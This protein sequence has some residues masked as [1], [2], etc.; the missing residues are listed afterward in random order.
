MKSPALR[1]FRLKLQADEPV[2]GLWVT[3]EAPAITDIATGLGLDWVVIDAELGHLDWAEVFEHI[4]ATARSETV[5]LVRL[6][7]ANRELIRRALDLGADGVVIPGIETAEQLRS[8]VKWAQC[9]IANTHSCSKER[10]TTQGRRAPSSPELNPYALVVP[11]LPPVRGGA[12]VR[13]M[14]EVD[15]VEVFFFG[16]SGDSASWGSGELGGPAL[17]AEHNRMVREIRKRRKQA[18]IVVP[19]AEALVACRRRQIGVLGLGFDGDII[20]RNIH[21]LLDLIGKSA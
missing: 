1:R 3:L 18:G 19:T 20:L 8:V 14:L 13:Q 2:Y 10:A 9:S 17:V 5:A 15:G 21:S 6:P 7:D 12:K 4:R 11:L 16:S